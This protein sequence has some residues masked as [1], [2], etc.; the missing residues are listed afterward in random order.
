MSNWDAW[1][2]KKKMPEKNQDSNCC[3]PALRAGLKDN[4]EEAQLIDLPT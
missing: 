2:I 3:N 4:P 1:C